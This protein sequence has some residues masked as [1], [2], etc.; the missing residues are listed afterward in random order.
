MIAVLCM[1]NPSLKM[2]SKRRRSDT[3]DDRSFQQRKYRSQN[4][5]RLNSSRRAEYNRQRNERNAWQLNEE[6]FCITEEDLNVF[7]N[8][9]L[10]F[11]HKPFAERDGNAFVDCTRNPLKQ[12]LLFYMNSGCTRFQEYR[13]YDDAR[14]EQPVKVEDLIKE[15]LHE[16]LSEQ[17]TKQVIQQFEL[18]HSFAPKKLLSCSSCGIRSYDEKYSC[19]CISDERAQK[20]KM[21]SN[22]MNALR[23]RINATPSI[24]VYQNENLTS[25]VMMNPWHVKSFYIAHDNT[26]YHFH[27][28]LVD[29]N[30]TT[31]VE[32]VTLCHDCN[33]PSKIPERSIAGGVD[34]GNYHR[35]KLPKLNLHEQ[36][37]LSA[38]RVYTSTFKFSSNTSGRVNFNVR[39]ALKCHSILFAHDGPS[40]V[41][42]NVFKKR[43]LLKH[44][45]LSRMIQI[46]LLDSNGDFDRMASHILGHTSVLAR[47]WVV[48]SWLR[49]LQVISPSF[50][51]VQVSRTDLQVREIINRSNTSTLRNARRIQDKNMILQEN[52]LGSDVAVAQQTEHE[53]SNEIDRSVLD[54]ANVSTNIQN[55]TDLPVR[56][57]FVFNDRNMSE[58]DTPPITQQAYL[59]SIKR[60]VATQCVPND[61][62]ESEDEYETSHEDQ[63]DNFDANWQRVQAQYTADGAGSLRSGLPLSDFLSDSLTLGPSFPMS[64]MFGK[65]YNRPTSFLGSRQLNHLLHQFTNIPSTDMR[66][67]GHLDDVRSRFEVM[68]GVTSHV[69]SNAKSIQIVTELME[70][71]DKQ[72]ELQKALDQPKT[73]KSRQVLY[74]YLPHFQF[75][76][77][78]MDYGPFQSHKFLNQVF[79]T[80]Q[81]YGTPTGYIT[82][83]FND[84]DNPRS[85]RS[86]FSTVSNT[87]FPAVFENG[88][89]A[90]VS[91]VDFIHRLAR[92]STEISAAEIRG[93]KLDRDSR[94]TSAMENP[95]AYVDETKR[96]VQDIC[97]I[98]F[99]IAPEH[100][101]ERQAGASR[102]KTRS[103]YCCKGVNGHCLAY[104]GVCEDHAKGTLH[105]HL[106]FFGG[107]SSFCL[108]EFASI[109]SVCVAIAE[110]LDQH[111][112]SQLPSIVHF[113]REVKEYIKFKVAASPVARRPPRLLSKGHATDA[114][115]NAHQQGQSLLSYLFN[116]EKQSCDEKIHTHM[117]TCTKGFMGKTGCRLC[118]PFGLCVSTH[119]ICLR[120]N[121]AVQAPLILADNS[122]SL[123]PTK[124]LPS[125]IVTPVP[126]VVSPKYRLCDV[127]HTVL[128]DNAIVWETNR[129]PPETL[130][131]IDR[132][133]GRQCSLRDE[134]ISC[135]RC[136]LGNNP[137]FKQWDSFWT[138]LNGMQDE[139]LESFYTY[140]RERLARA[141]GYVV[142]F[143]VLTSY[144]TGSHNNFVLLG[145]AS[146][147]MGAIFYV[148]PYLSKGKV[149]LLESL[150]IMQDTLKHVKTYPSTSSDAGSHIRTTKH[151][152]ERTINQMHL[153]MELSSYQVAARLLRLPSTISSEKYAF[154]NPIAE[155]TAS[156]VLRTTNHS[157]D[158]WIMDEEEYEIFGNE[159][160]GL[161]SPQE[162][163]YVDEALDENDLSDF[164]EQDEE[165]DDEDVSDKEDNDDENEAQHKTAFLSTYEVRRTLGSYKQYTIEL[166]DEEHGGIHK[167]KKRFIPY[168]VLYNNRGNALRHYSRYEMTALTEVV[169]KKNNTESSRVKYFNMADSFILSARY[170]FKLRAKQCTPLLTVKAPRH[171]GSRPTDPKAVPEWKR[172]ADFF[173]K[174]ILTVFRPEPEYFDA[175]RQQNTYLYDYDTLVSWI[176]HCQRSTNMLAK[177]RIMITHRCIMN[178]KSKHLTKKMLSEY[179]GR[180]RDLW[181]RSGEIGSLHSR[182]PRVSPFDDDGFLD[183]P[184]TSR[185]E[186]L[187][188]AQM[189]NRILRSNLLHKQISAYQIMS[190]DVVYNNTRQLPVNPLFTTQPRD[191]VEK[192]IH[193]LHTWTPPERNA[194]PD[195]ML[196]NLYSLQEQQQQRTRDIRLNH[197][198]Q[199]MLDMATQLMTNNDGPPVILLTGLPGTGK[200]ELIKSISHRACEKKKKIC[201]ITFN[202]INALHID[203]LTLCSVLNLA[204]KKRDVSAAKSIMVLTAKELLHFIKETGIQQGPDCIS[205]LIFDESSNLAPWHISNYDAACRQATKIDQ[206]FG[207]IPAIF[208]GD[209]GQI[210][211]VKAGKPTH[212]AVL[213]V[214][215]HSHPEI[216]QSR[217][218]GDTT[219][220]GYGPRN[221]VSLPKNTYGC[222]NPGH[223]Y[224][225][226]AEIIMSSRLF[227]LT[228]QVRASQDPIHSAL[229]EK[230][231]KGDQI[232]LQDFGYMQDLNTQ[233]LHSLEWLTASMI[234]ATNHEKAILTHLRC[235]SFAGSCQTLVIRW[236]AKITFFHQG[237][238]NIPD[239]PSY[240][241]YF[242]QG[243]PARLTNRINK[244]L[245]LVNAQSCFYHSLIPRNTEDQ[246]CIEQAILSFDT[247]IV[248]LRDSPVAINIKLDTN[249]V[250][251]FKD[252]IKNALHMLSI[253]SNSDI[254]IPIGNGSHGGDPMNVISIENFLDQMADARVIPHFPLEL[255]FAITVN[256]AEGQTLAKIIPV[257]SQRPYHNFNY[258][259]LNV[260]FTRVKQGQDIR[261]FTVGDTAEEKEQ[262]ILYIEQL[263]PHPGIKVLF[264]GFQNPWREE[265]W[266]EDRFNAHRAAYT[267]CYLSDLR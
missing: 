93:K 147:A 197:N 146:Q 218:L 90:G 80:T 263:R 177:F 206:V 192:R 43:D 28:E 259:A 164:I 166:G 82:L 152:L 94:A 127:L 33:H 242:V 34:L 114:F 97:S 36:I 31:A 100:F 91:A 190:R 238:N 41:A 243:A 138:W 266:L 112:T 254:V 144:L 45:D 29:V 219:A 111:Y 83:A 179:R 81:R 141:N 106:I 118:L 162:P 102:R 212:Q 71:E 189:R 234:V 261:I 53:R 221:P 6:E 229:V 239:E 174:Y 14:D 35:I 115:D 133:E 92:A 20:F 136:L 88:C 262:S 87:A 258:E 224:R 217:L 186:P 25:A 89:T 130:L 61:N 216:V 117:H 157:T 125:Y 168:S 59:K 66:L 161:F 207:G 231:G 244:A 70:N 68:K 103:F 84:L 7:E 124:K 151:V 30:Q 50:H 48:T 246:R 134:I 264:A 173:A 5:G 40:V 27:P 165:D 11:G 232:K 182:E 154:L 23:N 75:S 119:P 148:T 63:N 255:D 205:L 69:K 44:E 159:R 256:K 167:T 51:D 260:T 175:S 194:T 249:I 145:A 200:S 257:L 129:T 220:H 55:I 160:H 113:T 19:V 251:T 191:V 38:N 95:I 163:R 183:V 77:M 72:L 65:A 1:H 101:F 248:T 156:D 99:G 2:S 12:L 208:I 39:N 209:Y 73:K 78:S 135:F 67:L 158:T 142:S 22:E 32:F 181:D 188:Q 185:L 10:T 184:G 193:A 140:I 199:V 153:K 96:L 74:K 210:G 265:T 237:S 236:P 245:G 169:E 116:Q 17:E 247:R 176:E 108:E 187:S 203:G 16:K 126:Q 123:E 109:P 150:V 37:I 172:K 54:D 137:E 56:I 252:T 18:S 155:A 227:R 225:R 235:L 233:D 62:E 230:L 178:M 8:Y 267:H 21:A 170:C 15:I 105:F 211:P 120:P 240:Y 139:H 49:V 171:P 57:S 132:T 9:I 122:A 196:I 98:L 204:S 47:W 26:Y 52:S 64:F 228:E 253:G 46:Y 213:E 226:G 149:P 3:W 107:V 121:P 131:E 110:V 24:P 13:Y 4:R 223:P 215:L 143:N 180:N 202:N 201:K 86:S 241:E 60:T 222:L 42:Q 128:P 76:G 79:Q 104:I 250:D 198:Q 195:D 85:F 214:C 58:K